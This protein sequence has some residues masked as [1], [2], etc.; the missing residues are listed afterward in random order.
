MERRHAYRLMDAAQAVENVSLGTQILPT[1]ER[2]ARPLTK[3]EPELQPVAWQRAVETA[4]NG[5]V[6]AAHVEATARTFVSPLPKSAVISQRLSEVVSTEVRF[7]PAEPPDEYEAVAA[8]VAEYDW[9]EDESVEEEPQEKDSDEYYTPEYIIDA[10][11][12]VL[13]GI[14]LDPASSAL[15]QEVVQASAY[16]SKSDDG[17]SQEWQGRVW[18]NPPFSKPQPFVLKMIDEYESG[19]VEAAI[20]LTNNSTETQWGQALLARYPVCFV[21]ASGGRRSRISFWKQTPDNPEKSNRYSQMI[22]YLGKEAQ[23]FADVFSQFGPI[24]EK[25]NED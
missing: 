7:V 14:D 22:F 25:R 16:Y 3:L 8:D 2:Q 21:G 20:V 5:K 15:A 19:N 11:R 6:T 10:T 13:G 12:D 9:T 1:S 17:L 24:L 23:K 4:P 18:L